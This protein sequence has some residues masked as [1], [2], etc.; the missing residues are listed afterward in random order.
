ML[1]FQNNVLAQNL[2][3]NPSFE[4]Y[5]SCPGYYSQGP[6]EFRATGWRSANAGSPDQFHS[7]SRGEADVP[8]N[9]A[10]VADSFDGQGYAG[11]YMWMDNDR[12]YR[13]YLECKLVEPLIKDSTYTIEFQFR[14]S[15]YSRYCIDRIGLLLTDSLIQLPHDRAFSVQPTLL[16]IQ[17]SA[18]TERTGYWE[19][20]FREFKAKGGEEFL[21]IG[22]FSSD[23]ETHYYKIQ[24][25]PDQ[26]DML[27]QSAY[28]YVDAVRVAPKF[29]AIELLN[30]LPPDFTPGAVIDKT[31]VLKN[32]QFE[33]DSYK[34]KDRSFE[35]LDQVVTW[36]K[37]HPNSTVVLSGHTDD[38]G[39]DKYNLNLSHN[40]AKS[41]ARYLAISGISE[42]RIQTIP[43]GKQRPL[44]QSATE[45]AR[46]LNR[47]VEIRFS[48]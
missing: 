22:N 24:F 25:Q 48:E 43:Y 30:D 13:E 17:D 7:C 41:V 23:A 3:P 29:T 14:H 19:R 5:T 20:A 9:W 27:R 2:V 1:A 31:Y 35:E 37:T 47:R 33:F 44:V 45:D 4:E 46:A 42:K 12:N 18:L 32:I 10:G 28:Y 39:G 6:K 40:R 34:L 21:T 11:I 36:L 8:Y 15:S 26:Q 16:V 38:V